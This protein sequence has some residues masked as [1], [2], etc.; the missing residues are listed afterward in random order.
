MPLALITGASLGIGRDLA[1]LC[2][3]GGYDLVIVARN[4]PHLEAFAA[5]VRSLAACDVQIVTAD[6]ADPAAP[7]AILDAIAGRTDQLEILIN[8]AGSG[9]QGA[10]ADQDPAGQMNIVQ[11]NV[12]ALTHLTRLLLPAMIARK[13]GFVMNV[14]STAA[15]QPG[16]FMAVYFATKAYVLSLSEALHNELQGTGVSV[17]AL[18]PGPVNTEFQQ[19]AGM[20]DSALFKSGNV[21]TPAEVARIGYQAMMAR[22][23]SVIPGLMNRIVALSTRFATRQMT[24]SI[25]AR[26]NR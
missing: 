2:A 24:A 5:E 25:A 9:L 26:L 6:L 15:F 19:R 7:Q 22:K 4:R 13:R 16:P 21:M 14:A 8:N 3:K 10:F 17:T 23:S 18:C 1:L 20:A 11:L 12:S